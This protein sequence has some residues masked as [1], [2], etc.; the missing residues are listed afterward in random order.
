MDKNVAQG[1]A[2]YVVDVIILQKKVFMRTCPAR[3]G[4]RQPTLVS[5]PRGMGV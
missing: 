4:S 1:G 3:R 2:V 5:R